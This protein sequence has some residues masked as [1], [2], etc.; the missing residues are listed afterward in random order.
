[1]QTGT[2]I[3]VRHRANGDTEYICRPDPAGGYPF[4]NFFPERF[5]R[6]MWILLLSIGVLWFLSTDGPKRETAMEPMAPE[7]SETAF[8]P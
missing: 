8:S 1:M 7:K 3:I 6:W 2:K 5:G 4:F